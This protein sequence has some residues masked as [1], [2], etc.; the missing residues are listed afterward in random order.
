MLVPLFH[1]KSRLYSAGKDPGT[2]RWEAGRH[3]GRALGYSLLCSTVPYTNPVLRDTFPGHNVTHCLIKTC[4]SVVHWTTPSCTKWYLCFTSL[5]LHLPATCSLHCI[6][7]LSTAVREMQFISYPVCSTFAF[8]PHR[9]TVFRRM[10]RLLSCSWPLSFPFQSLLVHQTLIIL[11]PAVPT[12]GHTKSF[13]TGRQIYL[14][15]R[16]ETLT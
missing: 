1:Q 4:F 15:Q 7:I 14:P 5:L 10:A 2:F 8:R 13:N 3:E 9:L 6:T 16:L 11:N 12:E